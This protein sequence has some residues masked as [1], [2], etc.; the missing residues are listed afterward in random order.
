MDGIFFGWRVV[1]AAFAVAVFTYGNGVYGP[2]VWLHA[3]TGERGWSVAFVSTCVTLHFLTSAA[4]VS[5]LPALHARL[6]LVAA[7]R[8]GLVSWLGGCAGWAFAAAPW[9]L[10][11]AALLTGAGLGVTSG[12]AINAMVSPWFDR[13]RPAALAMAYN[14]APVGGMV[15]VPLW[16]ALIGALGFG[17]AALAVGGAGLLLLWPLTRRYFGPSPA[18]LG[19]YPDGA[20]APPA[21]RPPAGFPGPLWRRA[22]FR[23]LALPFAIGTAAQIGLLS[24]L[25]SLA[26]PALGTRGAGAAL[27]AATA[28]AVLGRTLVGWLLRPGA[29]R[30]VVAAL[31]F[32]LQASGSL[33]LLSAGGTSAA[34]L[35]L[36]CVLFG[37][38]I[39]NM[40]SL[41]PAIAQAEW[42]PEQVGAVVATV[43]ATMQVCA[44]FAPSVF[45]LLRDGVGDWAAGGMALALQLAAALLVRGGGDRP[46]V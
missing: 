24:Q 8:L 35:V 6:G 34:P 16:A 5:R 11:F 40:L 7:T 18:D 26:A 21:P 31:N 41:P 36:G 32:L 27:S 3:L 22:R 42:P 33:A 38:G 44:A 13:R 23:S 28:C 39:G 1:A 46:S 45:G 20:A 9:Q 15:F 29:D 30:R 37:L 10:P 19:L 25:F 4:V 43:V 14:G 12:A 17:P 2:G